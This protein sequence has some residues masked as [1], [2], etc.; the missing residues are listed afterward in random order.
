M[1]ETSVLAIPLGWELWLQITC[2]MWLN[3]QQVDRQWTRQM[4]A[5][6]KKRNLKKK[7][8]KKTRD[9]LRLTLQQG[10]LYRNL[11]RKRRGARENSGE[12]CQVNHKT[13]RL[14][15]DFV[16]LMCFVDYSWLISLLFLLDVVSLRNFYYVS[17]HWRRGDGYI[18]FLVTVWILLEFA[19]VLALELALMWPLLVRRYF[20]NYWVDS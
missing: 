3:S 7:R 1:D 19:S 5:V 15:L 18:M 8:K 2:I 10:S 14:G 11:R 20:F 16:T 9:H 17:L 13:F 12:N 4:Q 6:R